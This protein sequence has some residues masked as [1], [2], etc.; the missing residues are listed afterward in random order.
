[1][2]GES[3]S[4]VTALLPALRRSRQLPA[5]SVNRDAGREGG[6]R[7]LGEGGGERGPG[8]LRAVP[9]QR[10]P[11]VIAGGEKEKNAASGLEAFAGFCNTLCCLL[12]SF[13][14][15]G[16][17]RPVYTWSSAARPPALPDRVLLL[18]GASTLRKSTACPSCTAVPILHTQLHAVLPS[19]SLPFPPCVQAALLLAQIWGAEHP[20]LPHTAQR[21]W[22]RGARQHPALCC[23]TGGDGNEEGQ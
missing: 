22:H 20:C 2:S 6:C 13:H 10:E 15:F 12:A 11:F 19:R 17:A 4:P 23:G 8:M 5:L 14:R 7:G 9:A 18:V 16:S 21:L 1:M 3:S